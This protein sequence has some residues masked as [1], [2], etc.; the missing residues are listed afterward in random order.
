[1]SLL[2]RR[3]KTN[4]FEGQ[5]KQREE[6]ALEKTHS[7]FGA[8]WKENE[9]FSESWAKSTPKIQF[10]SLTIKDFYIILKW[11][12]PNFILMLWSIFGMALSILIQHFVSLWVLCKTL[13]LWKS[14]LQQKYVYFFSIQWGQK[15]LKDCPWWQRVFQPN[16]SIRNSL[17]TLSIVLVRHV[18]IFTQ[19]NATVSQHFL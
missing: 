7:L 13:N 14:I 4:P 17:C 9:T 19:S 15:V 8:Y 16:S 12:W 11:F 2:N 3:E 18:W 1:M 6:G 10:Y 5:I